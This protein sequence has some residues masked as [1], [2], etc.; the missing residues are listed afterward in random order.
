MI[1]CFH[2]AGD[3]TRSVVGALLVALVDVDPP[4]RYRWATGPASCLLQWDFPPHAFLV[5]ELQLDTAGL[6]HE[7]I[8]EQL[9]G[10]IVPETSAEPLLGSLAVRPDL[11]L[12]VLQLHAEASLLYELVLH[13]LL[14]DAL[15]DGLAHAPRIYGSLLGYATGALAVPAT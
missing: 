4:C 13:E 1:V 6:Q 9:A 14:G 12:V 3:E 15:D 8:L 11:F 5:E 7:L 2:L 10:E